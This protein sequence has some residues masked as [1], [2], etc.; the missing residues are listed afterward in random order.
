MLLIDIQWV[1]A[2]A[3]AWPFYDAQDSPHPPAEK[4]K[5]VDVEKFW[6]RKK[7]VEF[8]DP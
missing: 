7:K 2:G 6:F 1:E 8:I 3:A 4:A 5:N